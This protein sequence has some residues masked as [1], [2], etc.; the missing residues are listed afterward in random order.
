MYTYGW[1]MLMYGK[2]QHNNIYK[3]IILQFKKIAL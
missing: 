3:A 1:F 2:N